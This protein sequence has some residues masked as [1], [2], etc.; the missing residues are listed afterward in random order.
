[1]KPL[2]SLES[3]LRAQESEL[4]RTKE[5]ITAYQEQLP[6]IEANIQ[7]Y[8]RIIDLIEKHHETK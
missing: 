3:E 7:E 5:K 1:M 8:K 4:I 2:K 6:K